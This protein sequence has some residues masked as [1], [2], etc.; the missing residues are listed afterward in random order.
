MKETAARTSAVV[1]IY[2]RLLAVD[3]AILSE[4]YQTNAVDPIYLS[5]PAVPLSG[6]RNVL[7]L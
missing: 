1:P 3:W 2:P 7:Q 5:H 6:E 4:I